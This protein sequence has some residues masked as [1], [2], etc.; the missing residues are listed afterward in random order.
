MV[1]APAPLSASEHAVDI[2][3]GRITIV[4]AVGKDEPCFEGH[5]PGHPILPGVFL[6]E[7]MQRAVQRYAWERLGRPVR[8][9]TLTTA[10]FSAPVGPGDEVTTDCGLIADGGRL[11]VTARCRTGRGRV[12][13]LRATYEVV[14]D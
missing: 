13:S 2:V 5:Y 3:D 9:Q 11:D 6:V 14:V 4:T 7:M 10:R 1:S 12:A 8:L